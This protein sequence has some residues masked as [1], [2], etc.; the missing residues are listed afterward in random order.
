[1]V[2]TARAIGEPQ[3]LLFHGI[4]LCRECLSTYSLP[5]DTRITG[6]GLGCGR[7][8]QC[9]HDEK[10]VLSTGAFTN[11]RTASNFKNEPACARLL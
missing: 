1:M 2:N 5:C 4:F 6:G 8:V 11:L 10:M 3:A 9:P 7:A